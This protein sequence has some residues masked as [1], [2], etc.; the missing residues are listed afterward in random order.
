MLEVFG[1][2]VLGALFAVVA[3]RRR[4]KHEPRALLLA[5]A[6][7]RP[8]MLAEGERALCNPGC[9]VCDH[10]RMAIR[11]RNETVYSGALENGTGSAAPLRATRDRNCEA[12]RY[13]SDPCTKTNCTWYG[14]RLPPMPDPPGRG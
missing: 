11:V 3:A 2:A 7:E 6:I 12:H 8:K 14:P 5:E 10:E 9:G 13:L 4:R 1:I